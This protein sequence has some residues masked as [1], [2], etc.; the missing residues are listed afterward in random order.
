MEL[1]EWILQDENIDKAMKAVKKNKG[2]Y[3]IDKMSVEE[4]D[5][6]F[7]K[8]REEEMKSQIREGKYKPTPVRRRAYI[9]KSNGEK[10]TSRNT[11]GCR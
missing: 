2:A 7:A 1:I 10:E 9:P 6:Y 4:L 8:H 5:G 11:N 3:G